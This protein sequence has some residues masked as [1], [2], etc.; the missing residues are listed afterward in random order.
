[1]SRDNYFII[2]LLKK[3]KTILSYHKKKLLMTNTRYNDKVFET[4]HASYFLYLYPKNISDILFVGVMGFGPGPLANRPHPTKYYNWAG[5]V[6]LTY[7]PNSGAETHISSSPTRMGVVMLCMPSLPIG[8]FIQQML[9][10][11]FPR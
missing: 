2:P 10:G 3:K 11:E 6:G 9:S 4:S 1:M 5:P 7:E 8:D